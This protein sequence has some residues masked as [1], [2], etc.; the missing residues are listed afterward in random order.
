MN[1]FGEATSTSQL[2]F[3]HLSAFFPII[4]AINLA[5]LNTTI[6]QA[7]IGNRYSQPELHKK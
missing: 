6:D 3:L 2:Q 4:D 7:Q 5:F 1:Q